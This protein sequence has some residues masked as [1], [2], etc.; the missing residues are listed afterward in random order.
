MHAD[1]VALG[2]TGSYARVAAFAHRWKADR[3]REHQTTGRS[4]VAQLSCRY[5]G[6]RKLLPAL[7]ILHLLSLRTGQC[8]SA[9]E[10]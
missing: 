5:D 6:H 8:H 10:Q 3:P 9:A 7:L 4:A 2:F 1:L